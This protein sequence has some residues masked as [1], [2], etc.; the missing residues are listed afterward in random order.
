[1]WPIPDQLVL[2]AGNRASNMASDSMKKAC[3]FLLQA[4]PEVLGCDLE[5]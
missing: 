3:Y 1:V 5:G 2:A 4:I